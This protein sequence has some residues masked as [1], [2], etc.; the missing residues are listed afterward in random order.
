VTR[1]WRLIAISVLTTALAGCANQ[2]RVAPP[3]VG[4]YRAPAVDVLRVQVRE[5]TALVVRDVPLEEYV[6]ATVLSEFDPPSGDQRTIERMFEVQA[7]VSRSYAI[8]ERGR[9]A[10]E[11]F[12]LCSTS[13]CQLYQPARLR[14]SRW[15]QLARSATERTRG[16]ILLYAGTAA[17]AFFHA[18]CGGHTSSSA[19]VWGGAPR[20][21]LV[22]VSDSVQHQDDDWTFDRDT[23]SIREALDADARTAVGDRLN[24]IQVTM[25]D[26]AGRAEE[27]TLEGT[28]TLTVRGE[29]FRE[30]IARRFGAKS[31]R[32][33]LFSV[34]RSNTGFAFRGKGFGHG[35]GLCQDGA[36]ARLAAGATPEAVLA[37]YFPGTTL[38]APAWASRH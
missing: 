26:E 3:P 32:S 17:E 24:A 2:P 35:V 1:D 19:E 23:P 13:H 14:T 25:R 34:S 30:V 10:R 4:E 9:H 20:P 15:A 18:N 33:T 37:H 31:I 21:Y 12:D 38:S 6:A 22:G 11:G 5:G 16:E 27:I 29:V 8:A 7:I 36:L 28:R